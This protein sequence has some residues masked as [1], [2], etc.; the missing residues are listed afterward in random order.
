MRLLLPLL[1]AAQ[2]TI[3]LVMPVFMITTTL[4]FA[5]IPFLSSSIKV[6]TVSLPGSVL[7]CCYC[8]PQSPPLLSVPITRC[9]IRACSFY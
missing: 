9:N 1:Y 8:P 7:I 5:L 3:D 2:A 4:L 6:L